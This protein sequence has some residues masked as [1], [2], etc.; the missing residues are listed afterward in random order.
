MQT[1][2]LTLLILYVSDCSCS[3][4]LED[5][6]LLSRGKCPLWFKYNKT[7]HRCQCLHRGALHE[8]LLTCKG[9]DAI[10]MLRNYIATYDEK[11]KIITVSPNYCNKSLITELPMDE[12]V[13]LPK[14]R[15]SFLG[16][17]SIC[18]DL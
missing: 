4:Q 15:L 10:E 6:Q 13:L 7:L 5:N 18:V 12:Y 9:K 1:L 11:K 17:I 16:S 14:N 8:R 3:Q 2:L